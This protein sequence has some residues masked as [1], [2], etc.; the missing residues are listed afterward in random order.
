MN[1]LIQKNK[2][3]GISRIFFFKNRLHFGYLCLSGALIY[4]L[5]KMNI[6]NVFDINYELIILF[7][8]RG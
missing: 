4:L 3:N 6:V 8:T 2:T 5:Y 7:N 1:P